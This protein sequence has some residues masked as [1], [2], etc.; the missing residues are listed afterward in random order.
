VTGCASSATI[1]TGDGGKCVKLVTP[2]GF[3]LF[4]YNYSSDSL[5]SDA[6]GNGDS[7]SSAVQAERIALLTSVLAHSQALSQANL[8]QSAQPQPRAYS[9]T[10]PQIPGPPTDF[11]NSRTLQSVHRSR[12]HFDLSHHHSHSQPIYQTS[13]RH[14]SPSPPG[15]STASLHLHAP[16]PLLPSFLQ[17]IVQSPAL[18]PTSS[19][20]AD[21][22]LDEP[23]EN[24][25]LPI[26]AVPRGG[27]PSSTRESPSSMALRN[28][29]KM[30][31][32]ETKN[33]SALGSP[34]RENLHI[35]SKKGSQEMLHPPS[36]IARFPQAVE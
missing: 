32:E 24:L 10:P 3:L 4:A 9:L 6:E 2:V 12:S 13:G 5:P 28:I 16:A 23:E 26:G 19:S 18:S 27:Q 35:G 36:T 20:S 1:S 15:A 21:L 17:D 33:L 30:D 31:G 34:N 7:I 14:G 8:L 29:W 22:S 25:T 11:S